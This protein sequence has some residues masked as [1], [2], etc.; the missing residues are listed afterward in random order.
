MGLAFRVI[1]LV[2]LI[3]V[4]RWSA[5]WDIRAAYPLALGATYLVLD[6]YYRNTLKKQRLSLRSVAKKLGNKRTQLGDSSRFLKENTRKKSKRDKDSDSSDGY[7]SEI[8][9]LRSFPQDLPNLGLLVIPDSDRATVR[10]R[11]GYHILLG[12]TLFLVAVG[13]YND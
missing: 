11:S 9:F 7:D 12:I 2:L 8:E 6:S 10:H 3:F 4:S 13:E 1:G 5:L